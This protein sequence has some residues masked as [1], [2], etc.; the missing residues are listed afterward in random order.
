MQKAND[1]LSNNAISIL[2]NDVIIAD[3][4]DLGY[5]F[6]VEFGVIVQELL[7]LATP[8]NYAGSTPPQKSYEA[9]IIGADLYAFVVTSAHLDGLDIYFKFALYNDALVVISLHEDKKERNHG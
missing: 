5:S 3:S 7:S 2:D 8:G 1:L 6:E 9:A 4:L